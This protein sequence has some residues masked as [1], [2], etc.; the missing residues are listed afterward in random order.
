MTETLSKI[1]IHRNREKMNDAFNVQTFF[2][3]TLKQE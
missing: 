2:A 3:L 1:R